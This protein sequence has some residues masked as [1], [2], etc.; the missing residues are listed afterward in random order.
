MP[1]LSA[2]PETRPVPHASDAETVALLQWAS[3]RLRLRWRGFRNVRGTVR[4][5]LVRRMA[6]LGIASVGDYRAHLDAEP[7]EWS[8]LEAMCRI[9]I[10]RF[11]RDRA[12][13]ERLAREILPERARAAAREGRTAVRIWSAGC[14]SGEE[15]YTFALLWHLEVAPAAPGVVL[16]LIATD[17]DE[18][19][20]A[21]AER[22]V[23]AEGSL[24]ELPIALRA[25]AF[26]HDDGEWRIREEL[27][28]G[29]TFRREDMR[30]TAPVGPFDVIACRNAAFTYFDAPTQETMALGFITLLR[31]GGVLVVGSHELLPPAFAT[32]TR[33][34]PCIYERK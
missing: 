33:R 11:H 4:K 25:R 28:Q 1:P 7:A 9:P 3:P 30:E 18:T 19:M 8:V 34:A 31:H 15:P 20:T 27:R 17:A 21:R 14:A 23:Y 16:E 5:R 13:Y 22:G 12:V 26:D 32:L 10:S 6:A 29:V 24:R 2:M